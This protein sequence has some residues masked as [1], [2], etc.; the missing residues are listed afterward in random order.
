[1]D[2]DDRNLQLITDIQSELDE[3]QL[4]SIITG[5]LARYLNGIDCLVSDCDLMFKD[6]ESM[7]RASNHLRGK[8][9][10]V[11]KQDSKEIVMSSD[12][13]LDLSYDNYHLL[14]MDF[15]IHENEGLRYFD[16]HGLLWLSLLDLQGMHYGGYD[17]PANEKSLR[18]LTSHSQKMNLS[19]N[20]EI[21]NIPG[22]GMKKTLAIVFG[23]SERC[24]ALA[25]QMLLSF[26]QN[27]VSELKGD[28]EIH[29]HAY[30]CNLTILN[31]DYMKHR[32][33][34]NIEPSTFEFAPFKTNFSF[35]RISK[36]LGNMILHIEDCS[37]KDFRHHFPLPDIALYQDFCDKYILPDKHVYDYVLFCHD[38]MVFPNKVN[39][40]ESMIEILQAYFFGST[41]FDMVCKATFNCNADISIRFHPA[42]I[43]V[44]SVDFLKSKLSFINDLQIMD[45]NNF[46]VYTDGGAGLLASYYSKE[47]TT[48]KRPYTTIPD[49][50]YSHIR[51]MG[52]TGVEFCYL[53]HDNIPE[54]TERIDEANKYNDFILYN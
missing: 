36:H 5:S 22:D 38:D 25:E 15:T 2:I 28:W 8:G 24:I 48:N 30:K 1:M 23:F 47:N 42:F 31:S 53:R 54:F 41:R 52:D 35:E 49:N 16:T 7:V 26:Q 37:S 34:K 10:D 33:V 43:F 13:T 6:Q 50:W 19:Y 3:K 46:K 9:Y 18:Q 27:I 32:I 44:K 11:V 12:I 20:D 51:S 29:V 45:N 17:Y 21:S 40:I 39:I 4:P 14:N